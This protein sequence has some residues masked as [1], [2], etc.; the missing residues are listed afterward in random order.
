MMIV[1][2]MKHK[3]TVMDNVVAQE[4][5]HDMLSGKKKIYNLIYTMSAILWLETHKNK[6][7]KLFLK[8]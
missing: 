2:I 3:I 1:N 5:A 4:K 6:A 7:W 8:N